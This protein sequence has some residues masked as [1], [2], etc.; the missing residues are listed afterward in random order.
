MYIGKER[1]N[2]LELGKIDDHLFSQNY[3][4]IFFFQQLILSKKDGRQQIS[5]TAFL[6]CKIFSVFVFLHSWYKIQQDKSLTQQN[7]KILTW[8]LVHVHQI[9]F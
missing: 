1:G 5:N 8:E 7:V 6:Y 4:K 9:F 3:I 2:A